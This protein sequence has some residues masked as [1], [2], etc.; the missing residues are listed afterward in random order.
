MSTTENDLLGDHQ[1]SEEG[2]PAFNPS[3]IRRT[4]AIVLALVAVMTVVGVGLIAWWSR[5]QTENACTDLTVIDQMAPTQ[6][7]DAPER[8]RLETC[9][10]LRID[11]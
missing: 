4:T 7:L 11:F 3:D 6:P 8:K 5:V 2:F 9:K 1:Q 10:A